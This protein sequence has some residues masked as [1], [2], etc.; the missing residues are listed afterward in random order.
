MTPLLYL[1]IGNIA[2]RVAEW[3]DDRADR[4]ERHII[5]LY[6]EAWTGR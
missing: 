6:R 4:H 2:R 1:F 5:D 3:A